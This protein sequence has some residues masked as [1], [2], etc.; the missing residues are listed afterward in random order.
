MKQLIGTGIAVV[1]PFKKNKEIDFE[2][3]KKI[4]NRAIDNG[5]DYIVTLGTTGEPATQSSTEKKEVIQFTKEIVAQR[6][7]IV[8]GI[9]GNNTFEVAKNIEQLDTKDVTAILSVV[10]YYNKPQQEG[11]FQ[12]YKTISETSPLPIIAYNVPGR[13]GVNMVAETTLR[14]ANECQN[15]IAVKEASGNLTQ[16]THILKNR[17][18]NFLV[19]SGDDNLTFPMITMGANGVISVVAQAIPK[20]YSDMVRL[21]ISG[22]FQEACKLHFQMYEFVEALFLDGSPAG[23][24]AALHAVGICENELRLPLVA[25]KTGVYQS[26]NE[27]MKLLKI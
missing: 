25:V 18:K 13:T 8:V 21:A 6:V 1:T 22:K 4:L 15:V 7:P 14:L 3:L 5:V 19:I 23:V 24:K 26:I 16:I 9:G 20:T 11:I 2:A 10:P 17:P 27:M 12:H